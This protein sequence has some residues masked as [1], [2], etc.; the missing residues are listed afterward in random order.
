ML[1]S[2]L[3]L[4]QKA[5]RHGYAVPAFNVNNLEI[6][7]G[8]LSGAVQMKSPVI[9]QTSGGAIEYAGMMELGA[10]VHIMAKKVKI[11]VA[12]HLDHGKDIGLVTRAIKSGFYHSVMYDGSHL[13]FKKNIETT[14][15]IVNLARKHGVAVE[16]ELGSI[17]GKEDLIKVH[18][19]D[20]FFTD[21]E[22]AEEFVKKTGCDSLAISI[23][24]AHGINKFEGESRLDFKRLKALRSR[25]SLPLVLHGASSVPSFLLKQYDLYT[26]ILHD[27]GRFR[28]AKGVAEQ[29]IKKAI[30]L[31]ICK[32][33]V[34]TDLRVAFLVA[35][36]EKMVTDHEVFDPREL[37]KPARDLIAKTVMKKIQ[38]FGSANKI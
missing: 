9:V 38:L 25:V 24:T 15:T 2:S 19:R 1:F 27:E 32:V 14:R 28:H 5:Q 8:V 13:A 12:L 17:L 22:Q 4:L 6:L 16:A 35:I 30:R 23:G 31:G 3:K 34:D 20:V 11:P 29:H 18:E 7:Q 26:R 36:R 37:L 33:N 10:L 21:T